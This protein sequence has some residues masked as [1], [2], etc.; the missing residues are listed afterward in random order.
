M[1]MFFMVS[2][3]VLPQSLSTPPTLSVICRTHRT[4]QLLVLTAKILTA[5]WHMTG[6]TRRKDRKINVQAS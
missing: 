4:Q 5:K 3:F 1:K 2:A 6:P